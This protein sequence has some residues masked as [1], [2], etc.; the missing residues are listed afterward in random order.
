MEESTKFDWRKS[1]STKWIFTDKFI[2]QSLFP[3]YKVKLVAKEF[4]EVH[5]IDYN[6]MFALTVYMNNSH[7]VIAITVAGDLKCH[8][9][10]TDNTFTKSGLN[11]QIY[12]SLPDSI[13]MKQ[14]QVL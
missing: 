4:F 14:N 12:F 6:K 10:D 5:W 11:K 1:C 8:Q 13:R 9:V 3:G 7:T 2:L